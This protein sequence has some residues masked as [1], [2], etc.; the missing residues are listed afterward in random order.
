MLLVGCNNDNDYENLL[1][2]CCVQVT[3][4]LGN[5]HIIF[6]Q[7]KQI[8]KLKVLVTYMPRFRFLF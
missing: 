6:L 8:L 3:V 2:T 1:S 4:Q 7:R 5:V